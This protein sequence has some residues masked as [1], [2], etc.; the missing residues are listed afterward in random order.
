MSRRI[1]GGVL[2]SEDG[3]RRYHLNLAGGDIADYDGLVA[4]RA[5]HHRA[6]IRHHNAAAKNFYLPVV[7]FHRG[8]PDGVHRR[9]VRIEARTGGL[10]AIADVFCKFLLGPGCT[11]F[12]FT[13]LPTCFFGIEPLHV[14]LQRIL[15]LFAAVFRLLA[16]YRVNINAGL[17]LDFRA[18]RFGAAGLSS[19]LVAV[20]GLI[21][22][23]CQ[24]ALLFGR[25]LIAALHLVINFLDRGVVCSGRYCIDGGFK[26]LAVSFRLTVLLAYINGV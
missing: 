18:H 7:H 1:S 24:Y 23:L 26:H 5:V 4:G 16:Q 25:V 21:E 12:F 13:R 2:V 19:V 22:H 15:F 9:A 8:A 14:G 6:V 17:L 11:L 20:N 10:A 3:V